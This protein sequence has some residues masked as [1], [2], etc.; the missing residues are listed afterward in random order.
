MWRVCRNLL[1]L[2]LDEERRRRLG[3]FGGR[4]AYIQ[5]ERAGT[6]GWCR[7][8]P[9]SILA[10]LLGIFGGK[11][12]W[13]STPCHSKCK[14]ASPTSL[15]PHAPLSE[16]RH[17]K[18]RAHPTN[19]L[20]C[21]RGAWSP[22]SFYYKTTFLPPNFTPFNQP[23]RQLHITAASTFTNLPLQYY[24]PLF[25]PP[26]NQSSWLEVNPEER[27]VAPRTPNRKCTL[28]LSSTQ[29]HYMQPLWDASFS[30]R[31]PPFGSCA[32]SWTFCV[33]W[34]YLH[35]LTRLSQSIIQGWSCIPRRSC[36]PSSP[37]GKLCPTCRCR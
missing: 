32:S 33:Y 2:M 1:A 22:H 20:A 14:P 10:W 26:K 19:Q 21:D 8:R 12:R 4:C 16:K 18:Q 7:G 9:L 30:C 28:S 25:K 3:M 36:P 37:Q 35:S 27:P 31:H 29:S 13:G 24:L 6:S 15:P 23:Q 34:L 5:I 11:A 17:S